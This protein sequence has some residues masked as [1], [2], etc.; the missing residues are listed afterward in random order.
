MQHVVNSDVAFTCFQNHGVVPPREPLQH[1]HYLLP[2]LD[3]ALMEFWQHGPEFIWCNSGGGGQV[4]RSACSVR[5]GTP[6]LVNQFSRID[7]QRPASDWENADWDE[8]CRHLTRTRAIMLFGARASERCSWMEA[9]VGCVFHAGT[10]GQLLKG[11]RFGV[12]SR[13][14]NHLTQLAAVWERMA[15]IGSPLPVVPLHCVDGFFWLQ[16]VMCIQE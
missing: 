14:G 5:D 11:Q 2:E 4:P 12:K 15:A 10:A 8:V 1:L 7:F 13:S 6:Q 16:D 9:M 3:M